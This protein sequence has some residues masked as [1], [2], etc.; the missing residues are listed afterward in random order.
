MFMRMLAITLI[1]SVALASSAMTASAYELSF[2]PVSNFAT[3]VSDIVS[4]QVFLDTQLESDIRLME[5]GVLFDDAYFKYSRRLS[6]TG[7]VPGYPGYPNYLLYGVDNTGGGPVL[8]YME[9]RVP[10]FSWDPPILVVPGQV[11]IGWVEVTGNG[12]S[13]TATSVLLATLVF[14]LSAE[15]PV[16]ESSYLNLTLS[17]GGAVFS[18]AGRGIINDQ[19]MLGPRVEIAPEPGVLVISFGALVTLGGL[20]RYK[21][22]NR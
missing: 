18:I 6:T 19:V 17:D 3:E 22:R 1:S 7:G 4:V 2:G 10:S 13:A 15:L 14:H 21:R 9:P 5:I 12:T 20:R 11:N 16:D 8:R